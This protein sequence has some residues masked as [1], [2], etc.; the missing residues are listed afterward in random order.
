MDVYKLNSLILIVN[1]Y[2]HIPSKKRTIEE[3]EKIPPEK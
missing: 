3:N 2:I 1:E